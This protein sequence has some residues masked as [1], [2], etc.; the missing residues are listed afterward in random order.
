MDTTEI[1]VFVVLIIGSVAAVFVELVPIQKNQNQVA[2]LVLGVFFETAAFVPQLIE[3]S[4]RGSQ[5][6]DDIRPSFLVL[7]TLSLYLK[8]PAERRLL[9]TAFVQN[10]NKFITLAQTLG[11][12]VPILFY[13]VWQFQVAQLNSSEGGA[14]RRKSAAQ[15]SSIIFAILFG[16]S[17]IWIV[18][19]IHNRPP[20]RDS[21]L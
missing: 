11:I 14:G 2:L 21:L 15:V 3:N 20:P 1:A 17:V 16:I 4:D 13:T 18:S 12:F 19:V 9:R 10:N 7:I 8:L 6:T 5:A